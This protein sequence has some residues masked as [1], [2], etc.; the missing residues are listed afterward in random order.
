M[1]PSAG[2]L[3]IE[4]LGH[5][6]VINLYRRR[7][8]EQRTVDEHPLSWTT[9]RS[10]DRTSRRWTRRTSTCS[11]CWRCRWSGRRRFDQW[12]DGLDAMDRVVFRTG[13][14]RYAWMIALRLAGPRP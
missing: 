11:G 7:T 14:R 4:P 10:S 8:P 6:P 1:K 5:N 12:L 2:A 13:L 9:F 3:F